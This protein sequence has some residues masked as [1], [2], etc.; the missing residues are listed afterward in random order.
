MKKQT[1]RFIFTLLFL[2]SVAN[3]MALAPGKN[4]ITKAV[5]ITSPF[6]SIEI[7][8]SPDVEYTQS[9]GKATVSIYGSDNLV[10]LLDVHVSKGTLIVKCRKR[11]SAQGEDKLKV[12]VSSPRLKQI[13]IAGSGNV[14]LK[15]TIKGDM[16]NMHITGSG[17]IEGKHIYYAGINIH[18]SGSGDVS[19]KEIGSEN[20]TAKVNGSGN[21][22]LKGKTETAHFEVSGSGEIDAEKL[23][24]EKVTAQVY[25]SGDIQC[26]TTDELNAYVSSPQ[27]DIGYTGNPKK[28]YKKG[29]KEN[30]RKN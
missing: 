24:V 4:H 10:E 5:S 25:G 22:A 9:N 28:V 3:T 11:I 18:I 19:L 6:Q 14:E 17:N 20:L 29:H 30:I 2:L 16:L 23:K 12:I 21:I 8:G 26:Q 13:N 7:T 15:G 1:T 27:G